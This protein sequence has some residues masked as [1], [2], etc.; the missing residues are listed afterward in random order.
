M[1]P[2]ATFSWED[3]VAWIKPQFTRGQVNRAGRALIESGDPVERARARVILGNWRSAHGYPLNALTMTLRNR[4]AE[5]SSV[6]DVAQRVKR[7]VSIEHKLLRRPH[8]RATQMQ[9]IGGCRAV[10]PSIQGVEALATIYRNRPSRVFRL[11]KS[12]DWIGGPK[13][14][15]YRSLH[16]VYKYFSPSK[17]EWENMRLEV[18]IRSQEQH[19]WATAVEA[20]GLFTGQDFKAGEGDEKWLR[21]FQLMAHV[22]AVA[23]GAAPVRGVPDTHEAFYDE[24]EFLWHDL[25][26]EALLT[27][28]ATAFEYLRDTRAARPH[29][30]RFLLHLDAEHYRLHVYEFTRGEELEATESLSTLEAKYLDDP[31][32]HVVLVSASDIR[33]V[34]KSYPAFFADTTRFR[35]GARHA[36][37]NRQ[38]LELSL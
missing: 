21:F 27:G 30:F 26:V 34:E 8:E 16:L 35:E 9:D 12:D 2:A 23:E 29:T 17:P 5:V 33:A 18:Q 37:E 25:D 28:W 31:L 19:V 3:S 4:A 7:L 22:G 1:M 15:G 11:H 14:T 24:L 36:V 20:V 6:A 32:N 38:Q 10:V 13:H